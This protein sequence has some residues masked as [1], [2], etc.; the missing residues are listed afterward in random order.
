MAAH[1][2]TI[3]LLLS[4]A[5]VP[6]LKAELT[7][8]A[9]PTT[10]TVGLTK[11]VKIESLFSRDQSTNLVFVTSLNLAHS[12][13]TDNPEFQDLISITSFDSQVYGS[14]NTSRTQ[15]YGV[16]DNKGK[17]FLGL[18]WDFPTVDRAGVYKCEATGLNKMGKHVALSNS[19][20]ITALNPENSQ[21]LELVHA[22]INKVEHLEEEIKATKSNHA[23]L[24]NKINQNSN[25]TTN[26]PS[27]LNETNAKLYYLEDLT[28][29][30]ENHQSLS[31]ELKVVNDKV[32]E[33]D[34]NIRILLRQ[35]QMNMSVMS[36][37]LG[38]I[39]RLHDIMTS[40]FN[41]FENA[42]LTPTH[43]FNGKRYWLT[44]NNSSVTP[45]WA[46][47]FCEFRGG[48]LAEIDSPEEYTFVRDNLLIRSEVD[49]VFVS[50]SDE[51]QK[52]LWKH[53]NSKTVLT[54]LN[55]ATDE[56]V[57]GRLGN[58]MAYCRG[59]NWLLV[60]IWCSILNESHNGVGYLCEIPS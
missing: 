7:V 27:Q 1:L 25:F 44:K 45:V 13:T 20:N 31:N 14:V 5:E 32:N 53:M 22:L 35:I 40:T 48:Y 4:V 38:D 10:F 34:E 54:Y 56:N 12:K 52:G 49:Y 41:T 11:N 9:T 30:L 36:Q 42:F 46:L 2:C 60:D 50:G 18:V 47:L 21:V 59:K 26:V 29:L 3:F 37:H 33:S 15:V 16:I 8:N 57:D 58:C 39:L 23:E 6:M 28:K 17:S 19:T 51:E 55:W 24:E 43:P